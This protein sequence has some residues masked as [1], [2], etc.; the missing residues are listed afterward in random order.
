[1]AQSI[2]NNNNFNLKNSA[3]SAI[4]LVESI[5]NYIHKNDCPYLSMDISHLNIL[6]A[7]RVTLVCSTYHWEKYPEGKISWK[8]PS[9]EVKELVNPLSLGN[10]SLFTD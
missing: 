10:I 3:Q 9:Q 7:S 8:I 4:E 2:L 5:K 1:M 6:D